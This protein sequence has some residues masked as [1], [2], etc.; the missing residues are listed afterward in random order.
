MITINTILNQFFVFFALL[1]LNID[2]FCFKNSKNLSC[3]D[4]LLTYFKTS[5]MKL[6]VFETGI[7]DHHKII[8]II[9]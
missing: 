9:M 4:L 6:K 8:S 5:T 7:S 1:P 2:S 3:I